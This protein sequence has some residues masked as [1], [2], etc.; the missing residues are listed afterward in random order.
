MIG[1]RSQQFL[2]IAILLVVAVSIAIFS[3]PPPSA[4]F[5]RPLNVGLY[6]YP[7]YVEREKGTDEF[8]GFS[9][10]ILNA[11][12]ADQDLTLN[13]RLVPFDDLFNMLNAGELDLAPTLTILPEREK[14]ISFSWPFNEVGLQMITRKSVDDVT[15]L[16]DLKRKT[17][18]AYPGTSEDYCRGLEKAGKIKNLVILTSEDAPYQRLIDGEI[19]VIINDYPVNLYQMNK[20]PGALKIV[21]NV[22]TRHYTGIG[23]A[24]NNRKLQSI[25]NNGLK[26]IVATNAYS[27]IY[28][29][30]LRGFS[31]LSKAKYQKRLQDRKVL[32]VGVYVLPPYCMREAGGGYTGFDVQLLKAIAREQGLTVELREVPFDKLFKSLNNGDIDVAPTL[33]VLPWRQKIIDFSWP[34]NEVGQQLMVEQRNREIT[35]LEDLKDKVVATYPGTGE[36]FCQDLKS[37]GLVKDVIV[38]DETTEPYRRLAQGDVDAV[39][40]DFPV[41]VY[42]QNLYHN[43]IHNVG[44]LLT[45]SYMGFG[46]RKGDDELR[47]CLNQGLQK[48]M[49]SG[50]YSQIYQRF[51][52]I[53]QENDSAGNQPVDD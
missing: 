25:L 34:F 13:F 31:G 48:V 33:T 40:N 1:K 42:F 39:I 11:I 6:L 36:D 22:L 52:N 24:K 7:P 8:T 26:N 47:E 19:D 38:Y 21:G 12:A 51:M 50:E 5:D 32:R 3:L 49:S 20:H 46:L 30:Y 28:D 41:N 45:H 27:E 4:P 14:L 10:E 18:G 44:P 53:S 23:V 16:D 43:D 15:G 17:V 29:K 37:E 2:V 35:S 9:V